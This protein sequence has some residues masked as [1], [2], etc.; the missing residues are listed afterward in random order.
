MRVG[1]MRAKRHTIWMSPSSLVTQNTTSLNK[2][3]L[4]SRRRA[5][6]RFSWYHWLLG[7]S[8]RIAVSCPGA[9]GLAGADGRLLTVD[10]LERRW[11][12]QEVSA[13]SSSNRKK[14][15]S[16]L[17][18]ILFTQAGLFTFTSPGI[19]VLSKSSLSNRIGGQRL[20]L[21]LVV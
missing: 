10:G 7:S 5:D 21:V 4:H 16:Q 14:N 15:T 13:F 6:S 18:N 17:T 11:K 12:E 3:T 19:A 9:S 20:S 8:V 1:L 2:G